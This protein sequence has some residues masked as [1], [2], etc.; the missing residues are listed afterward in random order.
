VL[1]LQEYITVS[2]FYAWHS[3]RN[4]ET[5]SFSFLKQDTCL[6]LRY[7]QRLL[8]GWCEQHRVYLC[9]FSGSATASFSGLVRSVMSCS[10][11]GADLSFILMFTM[12]SDGDLQLLAGLSPLGCA[13]SCEEKQSP[14]RT[15]PGCTSKAE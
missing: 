10:G 8:T 5:L 4:G 9:G 15:S 13:H 6:S 12:L 3:Y 2:G 1:I 14:G 7:F 11:R